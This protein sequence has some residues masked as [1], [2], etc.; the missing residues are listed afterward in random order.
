[1][2]YENLV[3]TTTGGVATITIN[4]PGAMNAINLATLRELADAVQVMSEAPA[5]RA[6]IIT[7]AGAKAFVAGAD[8]KMLEGLDAC[9][10]RE[11]AGIGRE[12]CRGI[13]QGQKPYIAAINGYALGGGCELA[14][15][16]DIRIAADTAWFGQPEITIGTVPGFGGT[17]RLPRLVG[18]GRALEMILT[19]E[20]IDA[21]EAWRIGLV[22]RV[23]TSDELLPAA[24]ELA[25][26]LAGKSMVA[27]KFC[28]EAVHNGM[29]M[30]LPQA[31]RYEADLFAL[32]FATTDQKE[33]MRAFFE[34][35]SP[36]FVDK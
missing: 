2:S 6:V 17:Q 15:S 28:R 36:V 12:L 9:G 23:V 16:C 24:H 7:G 18:K 31:C 19:G 20:M 25:L 35:R 1:M 26:K 29:E 11:I 21:R 10:A 32:S 33:G 3:T 8:I 13:E 4:R 5:V 30:A 34:K 27:M 14:M 22:N